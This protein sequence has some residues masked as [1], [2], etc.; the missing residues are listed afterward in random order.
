MSTILDS[1][2]TIISNWEDAKEYLSRAFILPSGK[3]EDKE[4]VKQDKQGKMKEEEKDLVPSLYQ[5][6]SGNVIG[7]TTW[8]SW[9]IFTN[10]ENK[11]DI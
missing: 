2:N 6:E 10:K 4:E 8:T 7:L 9:T 1:T 3:E 11:D 5:E